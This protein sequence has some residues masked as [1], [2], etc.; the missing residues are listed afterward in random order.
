M[1]YQSDIQSLI[2][3][4]IQEKVPSSKIEGFLLKEFKDYARHTSVIFLYQYCD[5]E[6]NR[7]RGRVNQV[8]GWRVGTINFSRIPANQRPRQRKPA[9]DLTRY[10]DLG[11][12]G[13]RSFRDNCFIVISAFLNKKT[14]QWVDTPEEA[15]LSPNKRDYNHLFKWQ[16]VE[17]T[18][19]EKRKREE[20]RIKD[21]EKRKRQIEENGSIEKSIHSRGISI[22]KNISNSFK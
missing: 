18:P 7:L 12:Y 14:K 9:D 13:W 8:A 21:E 19:E 22:K 3:K 15:G 16:D 4:A 1:S 20:V 11:R 17:D 6:E 2:Q 5:N 10:Y